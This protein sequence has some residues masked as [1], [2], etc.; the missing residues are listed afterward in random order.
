MLFAEMRSRH[1]IVCSTESRKLGTDSAGLFIVVSL[2]HFWCVAFKD[3]KGEDIF[4][5]D[6]DR[7]EIARMRN[8]PDKYFKI[9]REFNTKEPPASWLVW[10]HSESKGWCD[11]V[12]GT[13]NHNTVS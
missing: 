7:S 10:P 12:T 6:A 3:R 13:L 2:R 9:W 5:K 1:S 4:R 8:D 11:Q